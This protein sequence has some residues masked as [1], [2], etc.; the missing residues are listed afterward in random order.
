MTGSTIFSHDEKECRIIAGK[1]RAL[2]EPVDF[3]VGDNFRFTTADS[4]NP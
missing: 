3:M 4:G 2:L 1:T